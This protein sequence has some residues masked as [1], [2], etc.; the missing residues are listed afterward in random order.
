[1][2]SMGRDYS[3]IMADV[4]FIGIFS[5]QMRNIGDGFLPGAAPAG[6]FK[7]T[8]GAR[9]GSRRLG[10]EPCQ[11][12]RHSPP[13][14]GSCRT[15]VG[16]PRGAWPAR[17]AVGISSTPGR[18]RRGS[19]GSWRHLRQR[20]TQSMVVDLDAPQM[21]KNPAGRDAAGRAYLRL[22]RRPGVLVGEPDRPARSPWRV[23]FSWL[24]DCERQA[25]LFWVHV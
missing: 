3:E 6:T 17:S 9:P 2:K 23:C 13:P 10:T 12:P 21:R 8:N 4:D 19:C 14:P 18:G 7:R 15:P 25:S 20:V 5:A 22:G 11:R 24:V 1:M 16:R